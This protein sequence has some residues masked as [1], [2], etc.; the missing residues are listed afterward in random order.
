MLYK[1]IFLAICCSEIFAIELKLS[2]VKRGA[3][4]PW[5]EFQ[6]SHLAKMLIKRKRYEK[7]LV[8]S[9]KINSQSVFQLRKILKQ[10]QAGAISNSEN[11]RPK[12][13]PK[14][15]KQKSRFNGYRRFH[16]KNQ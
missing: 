2:E 15:H 9:K 14:I 4:D 8:V 10:I 7:S 6:L 11:I 1:F 13:M 12:V 3:N 16:F 5:L